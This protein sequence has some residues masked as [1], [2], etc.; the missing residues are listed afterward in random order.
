MENELYVEIKMS[1]LKQEPLLSVQQQQRLLLSFEMQQA[2]QV[3]QMPS[4]ELSEWLKNE[5]EENPYLEYERGCSFCSRIQKNAQIAEKEHSAT[6]TL[7][8]YL[9]EQARLCF[10]EKELKTA[11][12]L[13][14]NLDERG[15]LSENEIG[16]EM[17]AV[18][19]KIQNFDPPGIAARNL[20]ESLMIQLRFKEKVDSPA[21]ALLDQH[22][23]DLLYNRL[24]VLAKKMKVTIYQLKKWIEEE[25]S[26]LSLRPASRF[27]NEVNAPL[28]PD[29]ILHFE[30]NKW[31]VQI[32]EDC[33]PRFAIK[34]KQV[35]N[36]Y[37]FQR[38]NWLKK[39]LTNRQKTLSLICHYLT[40]KQGNFLSG[41]SSLLEPMTMQEVAEE[42]QLHI[43]T[44]AR[45]VSQKHILCPR[46]LLSIRSLFC[47][48]LGNATSN[49]AAKKLLLTLIENENKKRPLSDD[50]LALKISAQG[51]PLARR[52]IAKYRKQ[53]RIPTATQRKQW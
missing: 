20:R 17:E 32:N 8:D 44:I 35:K 21:Y 27:F 36:K 1:L 7:F 49:D 28:I 47:Y 38:L 33:L 6:T 23:E 12:Y 40:K 42:L 2:I 48:D 46:G 4:L 31:D 37:Y 24:P 50:A 15:F 9:M 18:L 52:T 45:A 51:I 26:T 53:Y 19:L 5:I 43:S 41:E 39:A 34:Q 13:I 11:E 10:T 29:L 22:Y 16:P 25:I 30:E 14:G 3:L